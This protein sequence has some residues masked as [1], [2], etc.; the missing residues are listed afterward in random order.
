MHWEAVL[1][2][3]NYAE[4]SAYSPLRSETSRYQRKI[5]HN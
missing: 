2:L 3:S 5:R 4:D 1:E